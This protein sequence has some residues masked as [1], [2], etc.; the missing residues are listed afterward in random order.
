M[1]RCSY[2]LH[3]RIPPGIHRSLRG[4][5]GRF[6][7]DRILHRHTYQDTI[8]S[9]RDTMNMTLAVRSTRLR[10]HQDRVHSR[11]NMRCSSRIFRSIRHRTRPRRNRSQWDRLYMFHYHCTVHH[12]IQG[13][14]RS[15]SS[16]SGSLL[17]RC[18]ARLRI[19]PGIRRSH[20]GTLS[21]IP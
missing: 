3:H 12:R 1:S 19:L 8:H 17:V 16:K 5:P 6:R 20:E 18:S 11:R 7:K 21:T 15:P 14:V 9:R 10:I 4:S 13:T 2:I